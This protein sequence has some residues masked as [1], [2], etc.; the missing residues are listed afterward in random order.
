[1]SRG[2]DLSG[3]ALFWLLLLIAQ[4]TSK[5]LIMRVAVGGKGKFLYSAAVLATEG[6]KA[7]LSCVWVLR[8]GGTPASII[9]FLRSEWRIF[10]RVMVP[11]GIYNAQQML[12]FV[13]LARLEARGACWAGALLR[14]A[15][16]GALAARQGRHFA[17][18]AALDGGGAICSDAACAPLIALVECL[19][20]AIAH[21]G[22]P[23]GG[24]KTPGEASA[25]RRPRKS[26]ARRATISSSVARV[27]TA[28]GGCTIDVLPKKVSGSSVAAHASH[29]TSGVPSV[30]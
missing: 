7:T 21:G 29:S 22:G 26:H 4:N 11:A 5:T 24:A 9:H 20:A 15:P 2:S 12:E 6:L 13:A 23:E 30:R 19:A 10:V 25:S 1:M 8:N 28:S 16:G 18:S 17:H 27:A 14:P 3:A